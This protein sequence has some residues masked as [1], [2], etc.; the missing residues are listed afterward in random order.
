MKKLFISCPMKSRT[1]ENIEKSMDKMH[2]IA[3]AAFEQKL[4]VIPSYIED[5]PPKDNRKAV[6]YLGESIKLLAQADYFIGIDAYDFTG[7]NIERDTARSYYI[8]FYLLP[9]K[10][11]VTREELEESRRV[12]TQTKCV[13]DCSK[14]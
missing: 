13:C 7:C 9:I 12:E 6:W 3:E 1:K 14:A 2:R 5:L 8:P 11:A 10:F 4:E